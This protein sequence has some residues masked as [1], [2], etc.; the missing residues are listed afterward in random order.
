MF[1]PDVIPAL[2][3]VRVGMRVAAE[4]PPPLLME[5]T[6][7]VT[8]VRGVLVQGDAEPWMPPAPALFGPMDAAGM[9]Q[10]TP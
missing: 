4:T 9:M 5:V 1:I 7:R 10:V 3:G 2:L 8:D 6:L